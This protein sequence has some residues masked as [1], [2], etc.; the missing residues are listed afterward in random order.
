MI[1]SAKRTGKPLFGS[2]IDWSHPIHKGILGCWLFNGGIG[3]D[4]NL[5]TGTK[6]S[7]LTWSNGL[8]TSAYGADAAL[9][10]LPKIDAIPQCTIIGGFLDSASGSGDTYFGKTNLVDKF[11]CVALEGST[12]KV[13][14]FA[15]QDG[16]NYVYGEAAVSALTGQP[17]PVHVALTFNGSASGNAK[18]LGYASGAP[19]ALSYTS[20]GNATVTTNLAGSSF[21][22]I[23]DNAGSVGKSSWLMVYDRVFS[24]TEIRQHH[25]LTA[26]W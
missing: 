7:N 16:S 21:G 23:K 11:I 3:Q 8:A 19:L 14:L 5:V 6:S 12:S 20:A 2:Q 15:V 4:V 22:I 25:E 24:A 1:F 13:F 18:L 26:G 9:D 17:K 10:P